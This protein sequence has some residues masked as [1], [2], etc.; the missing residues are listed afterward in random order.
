[1]KKYLVI[2]TLILALVYVLAEGEHVIHW[3][4]ED[5]VEN[6]TTGDTNI[7]WGNVDDITPTTDTSINWSTTIDDTTAPIISNISKV[8]GTDVHLN[9]SVVDDLTITS[10]L[11]IKLGNDEAWYPY[12]KPFIM[13]GSSYSTGVNSLL[14]YAKDEANNVSSP[15]VF[16]YTKLDDAVKAPLGSLISPPDVYNIDSNMEFVKPK[17]RSAKAIIANP[18]L[19]L[20]SLNFTIDPGLTNIQLSIDGISWS[21]WESVATTY[22]TRS[23]TFEHWDGF[24]TMYVRFAQ[25]LIEDTT[26]SVVS[27]LFVLDTTPPTLTVSTG[28]GSLV[29]K[30]GLFTLSTDFDDEVSM[31]ARNY[32]IKVSKNGIATDFTLDSIG[33]AL[34][35]NA[36]DVL[37]GLN[38]HSIQ[39]SNPEK[40]VYLITV[41]IDDLIGNKV[42]KSINIWN[43]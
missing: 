24:K 13:D 33:P 1:V 10:S 11:R 25:D 18:V 31:V 3:D 22:A 16:T 7:I 39:I 41:S 19:P 6:V 43:K 4:T 8:S 28:N 9:I 32:S 36:N 42:T 40:A 14:I 37:S 5:P 2:I 12:T 30:G 29:S 21:P 15:Y 34:A 23:V 35:Y 38:S 26:T 27:S 17:Y 20:S